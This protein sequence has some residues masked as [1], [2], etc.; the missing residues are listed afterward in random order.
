MLQSDSDGKKVNGEN[1]DLD[2]N[3]NTNNHEIMV[4]FGFK[5]L[6]QQQV[7]SPDLNNCK[8]IHNKIKGVKGFKIAHLNIRS[9]TKHIDEF[10]I[11]LRKKQF[12]CHKIQSYNLFG[13]IFSDP[14]F[15]DL[16][17]LRSPHPQSKIIT[18]LLF[19][20]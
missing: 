6:N 9:L 11:F 18:T 20:N 19:F 13:L 10:R 2:S 16:F 8:C 14:I 3:I 17:S 12:D 4:N 5:N 15:T 7:A 1:I